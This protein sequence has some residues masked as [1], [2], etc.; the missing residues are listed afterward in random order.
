MSVGFK[1]TLARFMNSSILLL[2]L[3]YKF[4]TKNALTW[5][6]NGGLAYNATILMILMAI[7]NPVV[8]FANI[9]GKIKWVK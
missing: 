3:N 5:F 6:E 4:T 9:P 2:L 8:Y 7:T 1:L